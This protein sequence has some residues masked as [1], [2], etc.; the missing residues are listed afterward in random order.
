[1]NVVS[2]N[3]FM[4]VYTNANSYAGVCCSRPSLTTDETQ[5]LICGPPPPPP[6]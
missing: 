3:V 4:N 1:M 5:E 6:K 2:M